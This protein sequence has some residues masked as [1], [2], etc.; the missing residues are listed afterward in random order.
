MG[1]REIAVYVGGTRSMAHRSLLCKGPDWHRCCGIP[2]VYQKHGDA[3]VTG[4][5][6]HEGCCS[7]HFSHE[8]GN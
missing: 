8:K 4:G 2:S 6:N 3:A 7:C 1:W 5:L